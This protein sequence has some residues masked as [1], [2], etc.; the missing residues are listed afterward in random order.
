M[1]KYSSE[2]AVDLI[3]RVM[4]SNYLNTLC[5]TLSCENCPLFVI[6]K[7]RNI[8]CSELVNFRSDA[9]FMSYPTEYLEALVNEIMELVLQK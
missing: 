8:S 9:A 7:R 2:E 6:S 3:Y 5:K 4:F 1:S